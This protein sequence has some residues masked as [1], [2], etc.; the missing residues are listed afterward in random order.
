MA[1]ADSVNEE[2]WNDYLGLLYKDD[3]V[4]EVEGV[5]DDVWEKITVNI[6]SGAVESCV[7][8]GVGKCVKVRANQ[9]SKTKT[10]ML[11]RAANDSPIKVHGEMHFKG[12]NDSGN[13]LNMIMQVA[14][15]KVPLGSVSRIVNAGNA[16]TFD[17]R[18]GIIV[19]RRTGRVTKLREN[20]GSYE[21]DMW[22]PNSGTG[23]CGVNSE[24][25]QQ[26]Y[27]KD[28][29]KFKELTNLGFTWR[30]LL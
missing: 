1:Q 16:V 20:K 3:E 17:E 22:V 10:G 25:N 18:G 23:I 12:V 7:P 13:R 2:Q 15:V 26:G 9:S 5:D 19:N 30:D 11:Y 14:D 6:D 21:F 27:G 24:N 29:A 4:N 8:P 28:K